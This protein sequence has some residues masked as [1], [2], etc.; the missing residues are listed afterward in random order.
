MKKRNRQKKWHT[1]LSAEIGREYKACLYFWVILFFHG[2]YLVLH[3]VYAA[4]LLHI[5]EMILAT[6]LMGYL[7]V[8]LLRNFDEAVHFGKREGLSACLCSVIYGLISFFLNWFDRSLPVTLI[9]IGYFIFTYFCVYLINKIKRD[10]DT[11]QLNDM[12]SE[13]KKGGRSQ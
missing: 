11:D 13:Y 1:Y 10:I 3:K 4:S 8:Y 6:Y 5:A 12:L 2:V 9:F 7:Q